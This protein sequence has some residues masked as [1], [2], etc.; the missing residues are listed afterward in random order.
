MVDISDILNCV[1]NSTFKTLAFQHFLTG[2]IA[3]VELFTNHWVG[4]HQGTAYISS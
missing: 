2:V 1:E 3:G 4:T